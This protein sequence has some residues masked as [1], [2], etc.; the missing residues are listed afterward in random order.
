M[1]D[2]GTRMSR[3]G[4]HNI[5]VRAES[6]I[7]NDISL[8]RGL[9]IMISCEEPTVGTPSPDAEPDGHLF[10][11]MFRERLLVISIQEL[12]QHIRQTFQ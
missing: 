6:R 3:R 10:L 9:C 4:F 7:D 2:R 11:T 1:V 5:T 12:W 8:L